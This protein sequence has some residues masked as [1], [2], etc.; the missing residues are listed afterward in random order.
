MYQLHKLSEIGVP[1]KTVGDV[2]DMFVSIR[3]SYGQSALLLS[4]G[5]G[6][7]VYH[8]GVV[9]ALFDEQLLPRVISGSSAGALIGALICVTPDDELRV[10]LSGPVPVF[11]N[12]CLLQREGE[13][14][15][16]IA[17]FRSLLRWVFSI[18]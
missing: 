2:M 7:G 9:K 6:L 16:W 13:P 17:R 8:L 5:G 1:G 11:K 14:D 12:R 18:I 3:Q 10:A 4:G 15:S